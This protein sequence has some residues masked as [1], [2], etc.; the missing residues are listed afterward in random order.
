[1]TAPGPT[2]TLRF[3]DGD[4]GS[5]DRATSNGS[6]LRPR[7][8]FSWSVSLTDTKRDHDVRL[9]RDGEEFVGACDCMAFEYHPGPCAHLWALFLAERRA[10]V[11]VH[12]ISEHDEYGPAECPACG[13]TREATQL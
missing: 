3:E 12:E 1:M 9:A 2:K 8:L 4:T 10:V 13:K 7:G 5:Y 6:L 11:S